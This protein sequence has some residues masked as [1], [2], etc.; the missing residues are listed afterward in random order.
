MHKDAS[1]NY[2]HDHMLRGIENVFSFSHSLS[3]S[4]SLYDENFWQWNMSSL[5]HGNW[6]YRNETS[7][8]DLVN[9]DFK[10]W[11]NPNRHINVEVYLRDLTSVHQA[12]IVCTRWRHMASKF[13]S[14]V[15]R[16]NN[17]NLTTGK[18]LKNCLEFAALMQS[19]EGPKRRLL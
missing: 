17:N 19:N 11:T 12:H 14:R 5:L 7:I 9:N 16:P 10:S 15:K 1:Q 3:P 4:L 8:L 6:E 2:Y 13:K 18:L